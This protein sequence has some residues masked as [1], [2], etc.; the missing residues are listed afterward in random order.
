[1]AKQRY[2]AVLAVI[3]DGRTVT[4]VASQWKVSR[5][6][7]H[8]WLARYEAAGLETCVRLAGV[9]GTHR[10]PGKG[11]QRDAVMHMDLARASSS[12]PC[13]RLLGEAHG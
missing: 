9:R 12:P 6:T 8:M 1:V 13:Q 5:Q 7:L 10:L 3:S 11:V 2:Q 4:E